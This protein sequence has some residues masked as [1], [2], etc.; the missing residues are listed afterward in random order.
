MRGK[1]VGYALL[2]VKRHD[3]RQGS[4]KQEGSSWPVEC[5]ER[6]VGGLVCGVLGAGAGKRSL[7]GVELSE[8]R[9]GGEKKEEGRG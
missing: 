6:G 8:S 4:S 9:M 7:G 1:C 5:E 2:P 3:R